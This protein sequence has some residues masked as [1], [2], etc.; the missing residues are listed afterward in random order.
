M[1]LMKLVLLLVK[2]PYHVWFKVIY[3]MQSMSLMVCLGSIL[4]FLEDRKAKGEKYDDDIEKY[5]NDTLKS[6]R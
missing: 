5:I 6:M 3:I 1:L 4:H 2:V